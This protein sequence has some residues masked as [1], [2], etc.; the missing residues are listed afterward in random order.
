MSSNQNPNGVFLSDSFVKNVLPGLRSDFLKIYI[1]VKYCAAENAVNLQKIASVL[2]TDTATVETALSFFNELGLLKSSGKKITFEPN[3]QTVE[4]P[5]KY[6]SEEVFDIIAES[7]ELQLLL[8][9]AQK[10]LG[11]L[12]SASST[13][14]LYELY[15]WLSMPPELILR[16]L[17]YCAELGKK[18]LRY[19]EKVAISW[20]KMGITSCEMA[21]EYIARQSKKNKYS[22]SIKTILGITQRNYTPTEQ[23]CIDS[24]YELGFSLDLISFAYDYT[25][26]HTGKLALP[27]MNTTLLAWHEKGITTPEQASKSVEDFQQKKAEKKAAFFQKNKQKPQYE[28]YNSGRY[29]FDKIEQAARKKITDSLKNSQN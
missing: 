22:N 6:N 19:V 29:D 25:V 16:L 4:T 15:D 18:D 23:R 9:T 12:P 17:E 28:I 3:E 1:Y 13:L 21:D 24:W 27:Y 14:I 2:G 10:I 5:P 8:V 26:T 20:N 7:N 11:K